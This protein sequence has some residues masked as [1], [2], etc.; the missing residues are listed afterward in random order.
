MQLGLVQH[1]NRLVEEASL[2]VQRYPKRLVAA[3][4]SMLLLGT[5]ATYAVANFGPDASAIAQR[6]VVE[7]V[8]AT[9]PT[10][11]LV[12]ASDEAADADLRG[13]AMRLYRSDTS[14]SNDTA[15]ALLKRL[16]IFDPKAAAFLR[17]EPK[18][19]Q[20]VLGR[21][22]RNVTAEADANNSLVKLTVRW[23][24]H[25]DG[26]FKRLSIERQSNGFETRLETL[27]MGVSSRIATAT[28]RSSLFAATDEAR[29][30]EAVA[31]QVAEIFSGDIDFQRALRKGDRLNLVYEVLEGDAEPL[32]A[33]RVLSVE[34][35]NA[36]KSY[37]A[38]WFQEPLT[39]GAAAASGVSHNL[40]KGGYYTLS[41]ESL[42]R[43][44]LASPLEFSRVTSGFKM[45]FHP[46]LKTWKAHLGV[47]YAAATGTPVRVVGDGTV[48]F[49]GVQRGFGNVVI[50]QHR[51]Q[52]ETVY[53][54]LSK[55][56]V[57]TGQSVTQGQNIGQVGA[58]GWATGPHLHF[59]FRIA[60]VHHDPMTIARESASTPL[61]SAFRPMFDAAAQQVRL[62]L[63]AANAMQPSSIE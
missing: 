39:S 59:E 6:Q 10:A 15:E 1:A 30:P 27:P 34:F 43:A 14:R 49:A 47:D 29:I 36:G 21:A 31:I 53:G 62:Q 35:V 33:G 52:H 26:M 58:T 28:I 50:V 44:Y 23:S 55:I 45:R 16:G 54:H 38:M 63:A 46:V 20:H 60:G 12:S 61:A 32:R 51:N 42:R 56:S 40:S 19:L 17:A 37:Q 11:P 4:A 9:F 3:I 22:G 8:H 57:R 24:P 25:D 7:T 18:V 48:K 41:G 13:Q 2:F 5:G